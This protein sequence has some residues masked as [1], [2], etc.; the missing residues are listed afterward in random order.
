[1]TQYRTAIEQLESLAQK[2][3]EEF[4]NDLNRRIQT[5][6]IK[7]ADTLD[8]QPSFKARD[9]QL[10]SLWHRGW[11]IYK[12]RKRTDTDELGT[13]LEEITFTQAA[14]LRLRYPSLDQLS[15]NSHLL[16]VLVQTRGLYEINLREN[17]G[18]QILNIL[19]VLPVGG[20]IIAPF[21]AYRINKERQ[22]AETNYQQEIS[23]VVDLLR[24]FESLE[25]LEKEYIPMLINDTVEMKADL[26]GIDRKIREFRGT[27][28]QF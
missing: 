14:L 6:H 26:S 7:L 23:K 24:Y 4:C 18:E 3:P 11:A 27:L 1:M 22:N 16:C 20:Y 17:I 9:E 25:L 2:S 12:A 5:I 8:N 19:S 21:N 28:D 10:S 13:L 15:E